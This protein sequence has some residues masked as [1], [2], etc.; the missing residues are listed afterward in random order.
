MQHLLDFIH[1][2]S[3]DSEVYLLTGARPGDLELL[4]QR[5]DEPE[6]WFVR[7]YGCDGPAELVHRTRLLSE[8]AARRVDMARI[9]REL[10]G[11]CATQIAF[12]DMLL[13]AARE[14]LGRDVVQGA[15]HEYQT[16]LSELRATVQR[17]TEPRSML[18]IAG[19]GAQSEARSG[20]LSVVNGTTSE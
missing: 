3:V 4:W 13:N 20:H 10:H 1:Q 15:L 16:F 5:R 12:A 6:H 11:L 9:E 14:Q 17:L 19:G 8:L 18:L 2:H 7:P